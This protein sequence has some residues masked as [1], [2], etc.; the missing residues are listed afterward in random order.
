MKFHKPESRLAVSDPG[1]A[2]AR[3]FS[4]ALYDEEEPGFFGGGRAPP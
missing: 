4:L 2:S 3:L 1:N